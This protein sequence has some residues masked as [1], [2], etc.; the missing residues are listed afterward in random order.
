MQA[1]PARSASAEPGKASGGWSPTTRPARRAGDEIRAPATLVEAA[2]HATADA[3]SIPAVSTAASIGSTVSPITAVPHDGEG[4]PIGG[5]DTPPPRSAL[6]ATVDV[7]G[8][9]A[10][11]EGGEHTRALASVLPDRRFESRAAQRHTTG[12]RRARQV[13][14]CAGRGSGGRI[15]HRCPLTARRRHRARPAAR[16]WPGRRL[17]RPFGLDGAPGGAVRAPVCTSRGSPCP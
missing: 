16:A 11:H 4:G 17:A 12:R 6:R 13:A 3:G 14:M 10:A 9:G 7:R 8:R 1:H 15:G 2:L 5:G